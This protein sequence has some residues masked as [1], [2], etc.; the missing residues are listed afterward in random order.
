M[1]ASSEPVKMDA[2][3]EHLHALEAML[4]RPSVAA[5]FKL[6]EGYSE[7]TRS[8]PE[9][10][11]AS[12]PHPVP[13]ALSWPSQATAVKGLMASLTE[14]QRAGTSYPLVALEPPSPRCAVP[15]SPEFPG[16]FAFQIFLF[17]DD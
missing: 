17:W 13:G 7:E 6:D 8:Q 10:E 4:A 12:H 15:F 1:T 3:S 14:A 11:P 2:T 16:G 9:S 5:S